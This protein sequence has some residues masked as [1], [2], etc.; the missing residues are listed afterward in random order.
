[1]K[2]KLAKALS[3]ALAL[4]TVMAV[5]THAAMVINDLDGDGYINKYDALM[6]FQGALADP[7]ADEF[8]AVDRTGKKSYTLNTVNADLDNDKKITA[9]DAALYMAQGLTVDVTVTNGTSTKNYKVAALK[10]DNVLDLFEAKFDNNDPDFESFLN[11][12]LTKIQDKA[13]RTTVTYHGVKYSIYDT[14]GQQKIADEINSV[15]GY[16][17]KFNAAKFKALMPK[18]KT[19]IT[20]DYIKNFPRA[21]TECF[22]ADVRDNKDYAKAVAAKLRSYSSTKGDNTMKLEYV[23]ADGKTYT[24]VSPRKIAADLVEKFGYSSLTVGD[25]AKE[26]GNLAT[27]N[28]NSYTVTLEINKN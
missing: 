9:N 1:M 12:Y 8:T 11:E 19:D 26:Y 25:V 4:S 23:G 17:G 22:A 16:E 7:D 20:R 10:S 24:E 6:A 2:K 21:L 13:D 28:Y 14:E 15:K 3:L 18:K 27:L 5:P